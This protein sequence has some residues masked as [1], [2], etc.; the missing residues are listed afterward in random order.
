[1]DNLQFFDNQNT[2]VLVLNTDRE[3]KYFNNSFKI[4]FGKIKNIEHF[5]SHF[6]FDICLLNPDNIQNHNPIKFALNSKENFF[7][8]HS[9]I[10]PV[11]SMVKFFQ[12][13]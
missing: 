6:F 10:L 4:T 11:K 8:H 13:S 9:N 12:V 2:P 3:I 7:T 5:A 1:M